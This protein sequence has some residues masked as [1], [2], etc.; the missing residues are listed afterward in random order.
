M[1]GAGVKAEDIDN[2]LVNV[3]DGT[4]ATISVNFPTVIASIAK[5]SVQQGDPVTSDSLADVRSVSFMGVEMPSRGALAYTFQHGWRRALYFDFS[6]STEEPNRPLDNLPALLGSLHAG[7]I[8]RVLIELLQEILSRM[9]KAGWFPFIRLPNDL[10]SGLYRHFQEGWDYAPAEADI[11]K[12]VSPLVPG[13]L[14]GWSNKASFVPHMD[15]LMNA[16]RLFE[17]AE[18]AATSAL[19][20][21]KVEGILRT[22]NMGRGR[23][24]A[25][26]LR[27]NLLARVRAQVSGVTAFLPEAFVQYLETFYYAGFDLDANDLPPS[28][29]A[30]MHGVGPDAEAAKPAFSVKLLLMLDQ[31]FFYV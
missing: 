24:S 1:N 3:V 7:L 8:F 23:A 6:M 17:K 28:R 20:L 12:V 11:V 16:V 29:H 2:C 22:L 26:D 5:T 18:Y 31:L 4:Q 13:L 14:A 19:L 15:V 30:F 10:A 9:F 27:A 25:R 21:P